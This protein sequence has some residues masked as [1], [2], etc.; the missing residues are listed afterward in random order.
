MLYIAA[1]CISA[2]IHYAVN[3]G[4]DWKVLKMSLK[5]PIPSPIRHQVC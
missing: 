5:E 3:I 4:G 1:F 2:D